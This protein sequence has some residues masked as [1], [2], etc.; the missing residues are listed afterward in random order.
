MIEIKF[1][2]QDKV[3][4]ICKKAGVEYYDSIKVYAAVEAGKAL[5]SCGFSL[6]RKTGVLVFTFMEEDGLAPIEDG[7]L[8]ASL[9]YMYE[10]GVETAIC[11]GNI[12]KQMLRRLGFKEQGELMKLDLLHSFLT[13]GC[14]SDK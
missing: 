9:S 2:S 14:H 6:D 8:R 1:M 13:A 5:G 10:N 12:A 4:D 11:N 7:L 3:R